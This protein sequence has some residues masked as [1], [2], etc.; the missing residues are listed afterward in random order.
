[1]NEDNDI[2]KKQKSTN[3]R[4]GLKAVLFD[5]RPKRHSQ[6][7]KRAGIAKTTEEAMLKI[8]HLA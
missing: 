6:Q 4:G 3:K 8:L 5:T 2:C 1:M 7:E